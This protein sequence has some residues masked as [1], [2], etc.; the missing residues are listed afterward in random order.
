MVGPETLACA[1]I[2]LQHYMVKHC[3]P[4]IQVRPKNTCASTNPTDRSF[5]ADPA[6]FIAIL[7]QKISATSLAQK[8]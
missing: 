6:I 3:I 4:V 1:K 8:L 2:T 7:K 5:R